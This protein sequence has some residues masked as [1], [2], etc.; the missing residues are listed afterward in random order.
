MGIAL[1]VRCLALIE[2][3]NKD[4]QSPPV[5]RPGSEDIVGVKA[6]ACRILAL[7]GRLYLPK[8][9]CEIE[10]DLGCSVGMC[11]CQAM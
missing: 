9:A 4:P 1:L 6:K 7:N 8:S 3:T 10:G 5:P 2:I 11:K